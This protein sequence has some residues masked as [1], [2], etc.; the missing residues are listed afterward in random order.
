MGKDW[1]KEAAVTVSGLLPDTRYV[2]RIGDCE[3]EFTTLYE[4]QTVDKV[5]GDAA[6]FKKTGDFF[7]IS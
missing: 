2:I 7:I 4:S 1:Q 6:D 3:K 5:R